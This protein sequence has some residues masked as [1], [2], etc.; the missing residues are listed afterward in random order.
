MKAQIIVRQLIDALGSDRVLV[1][2]ALEGR[3][4]HIWKMDVP[5]RALCVVLPVSTSEVARC[6]AICHAHRQRMVVHG[7]LTGLTGATVSE[8]EDVVISLERMDKV[9]EVDEYSR[10]MQVQAGAILEQVQE[11]ARDRGLYFPLG[12][13]ARGSARIGGCIATNA[14]GVNVIKYGMTRNLVLGLEVVLPDGRIINGMKKLTK[15]NTGY[16]LSQLFIGSEGTLGIITRAVLRLSALP[17]SRKAAW[18]GFADFEAAV[19]WLRRSEAVLGGKLVAF[20][21]LW[22]DTYAAQTVAGG[23]YKAPLAQG[24]PFYV[25]MEMQGWDSRSDDLQLEALLEEGIAAGYFEDAVLGQTAADLQWFWNIRED[26]S[27]M[28]G[29]SNFAQSFDIS[30]PIRD[31]GTYVAGIKPVVEALA[32][33][34]KAFA[35]GHLGDG[36]IHFLVCKHTNDAQ[37]KLAIDELIYAPL[38]A[39]GGSVS[40]EHGIG[41]DKK[42]WLPL[43]RSAEEIALMQQIK[44]LIDP[45]GILNPG[46]ILDTPEQP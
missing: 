18:L 42:R 2:S 14:G 24:Y 8:E 40:A 6:C 5:L 43:S 44:Q 46:R 36:N 7:G 45:Y 28:T 33:V 27:I 10:T 16:A 23:P 17:V 3:Y 22:G 26:V 31:I 41:M 20:E 21:M 29:I 12:F 11:V 39:Y 13:G 37:L 19:Q 32:G 38:E 25:L 1:G 30:L 4:A 35:F 34:E 15:D 9:E